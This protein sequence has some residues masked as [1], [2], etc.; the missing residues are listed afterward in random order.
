MSV[1]EKVKT[2]QSIPKKIQSWLEDNPHT[3]FCLYEYGPVGLG[4]FMETDQPDENANIS[5]QTRVQARKYFDKWF[6]TIA[7][8]GT[9]Y[10]INTWDDFAIA[11]HARASKEEQESVDRI[12]NPDKY[13]VERKNQDRPK[14]KISEWLKQFDFKDKGKAK[15]RKQELQDSET[16]SRAAKSK[17]RKKKGY[18]WSQLPKLIEKYGNNPSIISKK[19]GCSYAG[20]RNRIQQLNKDNG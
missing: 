8:N 6:K 5:Y 12:L 15:K 18:D 1:S 9:G 4:I 20:A 14:I 7:D 13:K 19:I 3:R 16:W 10:V 11:V 17:K 2:Q